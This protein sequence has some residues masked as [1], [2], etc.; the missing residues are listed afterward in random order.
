[1]AVGAPQTRA[2]RE[3]GA[4]SILAYPPDW[5]RENTQ[6]NVRPPLANLTLSAR[7]GRA[8]S[9]EQARC[10]LPVIHHQPVTFSESAGEDSSKY[11]SL[12][13]PLTRFGGK[14]GTGVSNLLPEGGPC[15]SHAATTCGLG[16]ALL[17]TCAYPSGRLP[18]GYSE[19][20]LSV[21]GASM[22]SSL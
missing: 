8:R 3:G 1:V 13:F 20:H 11:H 19:G 15:N 5:S 14:K 21:I 17:R 18:I 4:M 9:D 16:I 22:R 10:A 12:S 6:C 2:I 7:G